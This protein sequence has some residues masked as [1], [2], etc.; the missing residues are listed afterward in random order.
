MSVKKVKNI[1]TNYISYFSRK[2]KL[3]IML[4]LQDEKG[5]LHRILGKEGVAKFQIQRYDGNGAG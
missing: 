4:H 1:I 2:K 3:Y 5:K